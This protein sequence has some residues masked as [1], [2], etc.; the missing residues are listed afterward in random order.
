MYSAVAVLVALDSENLNSVERYGLNA[1]PLL[2]LAGGVVRRAGQR[3]RWVPGAT[4]GL[5]SVALVA[6]TTL[7]WAGEY[8]P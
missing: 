2:I 1:V 5:A 4:A 3:W 6:L 8:V 7:A